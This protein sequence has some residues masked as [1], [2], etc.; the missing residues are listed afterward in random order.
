M[1][2]ISDIF[3]FKSLLWRKK[4]AVSTENAALQYPG[5]LAFICVSALFGLL[6]YASVMLTRDADR[7]AAVWLPNAMLVAILLRGKGRGDAVYILGALVTNSIANMLAGDTFFRALGLSLANCFEIGLA[8]Y[9]MT[10]MGLPRPNMSNLRDIVIFAGVGALFAP[11]ASGAFALLVIA[12]PDIYKAFEIWRHWSMTD[13]LGML[14]I[15]PSILILS[16]A[17]RTRARPSRARIIET[18]AIL[19]VGTG[20]TIYVFWQTRYPFLFLDAPVVLLY[21]FRLGS[22]GTAIAI[23]NLAIIATIATSLGYG[24]I[25]L[26]RGD[27]NEQVMVLQ[28]FLASSFAIGLPVAAVLAG[29]R[30]LEEELKRTRDIGASMLENMREVIFRVDVKGCWEFL[31]PAWETV[32]GYSVEESLGWN[33]AKLLHPDDLEAA[34]EIYPKIK[35]GEIEQ[36]VLKQRF[37]RADGVCRHIEVSVKALRDNEGGFAGT[38]GNIRDVT[39]EHSAARALMESKR[40]FETLAKLS[41]AGIFRTDNKGECTYFNEAWLELTGLTEHAAMGKGWGD[42]LHPDDRARVEAEWSAVIEAKSKYR[43]D[44]RFVR[45]DGQIAWVSAIASPEFNEHGGLL[46]Y[47]GVNVD[48]TDRKLLEEQ[49]VSAKR[50]AESADIAKSAFLANMS[51]EIRTPMNGVLG[52]AQLLLESDLNDAQREQAQIIADS[53]HTMMRLLNDI[54]DISKVEAGQMELA[55]EPVDVRD[56]LNRCIKLMSPNAKRKKIDLHLEVDDSVPPVIIGDGLRLR[57]VILNLT[58]NALKFTQDGYVK[59]RVTAEPSTMGRVHLKIIVEDTG[60]GIAQDRQANIFKPFEQAEGSTARRFGG[61]GLGLTISRQLIN[62][63]DGELGLQSKLGEGSTFSIELDAEVVEQENQ[64]EAPGERRAMPRIAS[65]D[66]TYVLLVEDHD[67]NQMLL[68]TM[69]DTLECDVKLAIN[70]ADAIAE[71]DAAKAAGKMFDIVLMDIQMPYVDGYEAT[72]AIRARGIKAEELPVVALTANAFPDDIANCLEAG[73]QAHVAKPVMK[74]DLMDALRRWCKPTGISHALDRRAGR[75]D[76]SQRQGEGQRADLRRSK[77]G[78]SADLHERYRQR[79]TDALKR[80]DALVRKGAFTDAEIADVIDDLHK[81]AGTAG[82]F[83]DAELG[84]QASALERNLG[85][86]TGDERVRNIPPAAAA[87][88]QAA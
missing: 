66:R 85:R 73:M 59:I 50:H 68:K 47:V 55:K 52:F 5:L 74:D 88:H 83:G 62:L 11:I 36:T 76:R 34:S 13:G 82:M 79:K 32:T 43:S 45:P 14:T 69:L 86:W 22:V 61:T 84:E 37:I 51:H 38:I 8:W 48:I 17:W 81:L 57:Q 67:V 1:Q 15:A 72:R 24:P 28:I 41:P 75:G 65:A 7:I 9:V 35:S 6:A 49:L 19:M 46:G 21:A 71:V 54:L 12:P 23:L 18:I 70:G 78:A 20:S 26:A 53:G 60:I 31:N 56:I 77:T 58:G 25:N 42:A 80:V 63:M 40:V 30:R 44:F 10:R 27:L 29:K 3:V 16:D 4:T 2:K 87:L 33:T 64:T 39:A